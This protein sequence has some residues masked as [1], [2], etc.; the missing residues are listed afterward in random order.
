[1]SV[2]PS[3]PRRLALLAHR[4]VGLLMSVFLVVAGAT[5]SV[6]AF[7][8]QID[9]FINPELLAVEPPY[10]GARVLDPFVVRE[11]LINQ[12]PS[13][14]AVDGVILHRTAGLPFNYWID[15]REVFVDPY[16]GVIKGSRHFGD[17]SEGRVNW[18]TF[19]YELH[20]TLG[21]GEVGRVLFG[22]VAALWTLDCFIGAYLTF[23]PALRDRMSK[24]QSS[25]LVRWLPSW[26]L[27]TSKL[28]A[29]VFTGHRAGG[30]WLW[31][32]FL[33]FAW[34]AV[35]LNLRE[36]VYQPIMNGTFGEHQATY[37]RLPVRN[38][39]RP[40][41]QL[42]LREVHD[43]ARRAAERSA[44]EHTFT[45]LGERSLHYDT[46][47]GVYVYGIESSLDV[48]PRLA[49]TYIYVDGDDGHLLGFDAPTG[50]HVGTTIT[51]WLVGLHFG[52]WRWGGLT[53]RWFVCVL[54]MV[55]ILLSVTGVWIWWRK[56]QLRRR[57]V[58]WSGRSGV[59]TIEN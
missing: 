11:R 28:F 16:T 21:L 57:P 27:R 8:P 59:A 52:A 39:T 22:I 54:G 49:E 45:I 14:Q 4:Y 32:M 12:L 1:M 9:R 23:P 35:A 2:H 56:R 13:G 42:S 10:S 6:M 3:L 7:Y 17:L 58:R 34:S 46:E 36:E 25:W 29:A 5:G 24:P 41:P 47:R 50:R 18:I 38:P 20:F 48:A 40:P 15:D 30:L 26:L 53:Y 37:D 44:Q 31:A 19:L 55:V 33:I 43:H 51:S